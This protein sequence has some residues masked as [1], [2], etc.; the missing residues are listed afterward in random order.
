M[1]IID[2]NNR[3]SYDTDIYFIVMDHGNQVTKFFQL[4]LKENRIKQLWQRR[5]VISIAMKIPLVH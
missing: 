2:K 3:T 1:S 5:I 4:S